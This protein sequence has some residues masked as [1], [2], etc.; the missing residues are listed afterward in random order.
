MCKMK[1]YSVR[2]V[3]ISDN[4]I[5]QH[6]VEARSLD[7]MVYKLLNKNCQEWLPELQVLRTSL[8]KNQA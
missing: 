7:H 4:E 3:R 6:T 1:R 5:I 2:Y 8:A